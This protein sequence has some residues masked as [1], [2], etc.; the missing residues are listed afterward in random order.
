MDHST[1]ICTSL[2]D[3]FYAF[4]KGSFSGSNDNEQALTDS[5]LIEAIDQLKK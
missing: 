2:D 1:R 4:M 5:N 3:L